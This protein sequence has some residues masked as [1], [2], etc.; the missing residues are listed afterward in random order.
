MAGYSVA[1]RVPVLMEVPTTIAL[2]GQRSETASHSLVRMTPDRPDL[3]AA[4]RTFGVNTKLLVAALVPG[5]REVHTGRS[6]MLA[7]WLLTNAHGT[8]QKWF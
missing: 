2:R 1:F 4:V 3:G 8:S 6:R 7:F 5:L